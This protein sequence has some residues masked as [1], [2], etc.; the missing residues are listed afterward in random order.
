MG[1][2]GA[3]AFATL[4]LFLPIAAVRLHDPG[5]AAILEAGLQ[6]FPQALAQRPVLNWRG[7]FDSLRKITQHPVGGANIE[8]AG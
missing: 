8:L 7:R 2:H 4:R 3:G 1:A 5:L 6:D